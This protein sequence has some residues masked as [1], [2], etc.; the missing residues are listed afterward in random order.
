LLA[1]RLIKDFEREARVD[2]MPP[3]ILS[4]RKKVLADQL[5]KFISQKKEVTTAIQKE[6][7]FAGAVHPE[8]E[9]LE[10]EWKA[11]LVSAVAPWLANT[12]W[13]TCMAIRLALRLYHFLIGPDEPAL[14][15]LNSV[16]GFPPAS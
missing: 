11:G 13:L 15:A 8:E 5:N 16:V 12:M 10:R 9:E 14:K 7:L 3:D 6:D 1:R 4:D 2:G